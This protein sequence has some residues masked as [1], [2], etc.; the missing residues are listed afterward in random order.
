MSVVLTFFASIIIYNV[1]HHACIRRC[2]VYM[3]VCVCVQCW[4]VCVFVSNVHCTVHTVYSR[5][6]CTFKCS[7]VHVFLLCYMYTSFEI[8][9]CVCTFTLFV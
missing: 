7:S 3:C 5:M 8:G 9:C 1:I 2:I 4:S 6:K